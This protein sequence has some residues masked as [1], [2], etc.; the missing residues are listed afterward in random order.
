LLGGGPAAI[1]TTLAVF[2]FPEEGGEAHLAS[3][4]PDRTIEEV[5]E[6]TGWDV[7]VAAGCGETPPPTAEEL[8]QLRRLDPDG[9]WTGRA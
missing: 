7:K 8:A 9:F 3:V 2:R 5:R 4:H 1:V 6:N